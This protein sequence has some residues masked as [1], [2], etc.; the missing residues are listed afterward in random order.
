MGKNYTSTWSANNPFSMPVQKQQWEIENNPNWPGYT[1]SKQQAS[2]TATN[3]VNQQ[4]A[5]TTNQQDAT[6]TSSYAD[7][8]IQGQFADFT[9][10][11]ALEV[12][13]DAN[14]WN[15]L[16][17]E[18][19]KTLV[20]INNPSLYGGFDPEGPRGDNFVNQ[21]TTTNTAT[22]QQAAATNNQQSAPEL[23]FD[24]SNWNPYEQVD[25]FSGDWRSWSQTDR[26]NENVWQQSALDNLMNFAK[27]SGLGEW[28]TSDTSTQRHEIPAAHDWSKWNRQWENEWQHSQIKD[29]QNWAS[30]AY[31]EIEFTPWKDDS[32]LQWRDRSQTD[33]KLQNEWQQG[34]IGNLQQFFGQ[35]NE[36]LNPQVSALQTAAQQAEDQA[37][38]QE[39]TTF[40]DV[41]G[42]EVNTNTDTV[43]D[44][45]ADTTTDTTTDTVAETTVDPVDQ[46]VSTLTGETAQPYDYNQFLQDM[47]TYQAGQPVQ[48]EYIPK[49]SFEDFIGYMRQYSNMGGFG[50]PAQA[51]SYGYGTYAPYSGGV[52]A[53]NPYNNFTNWMNAFKFDDSAPA[54]STNLVNL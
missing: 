20:A 45:V 42:N 53:A 14:R 48:E 5:T 21:Q 26:Y 8:Y 4:T 43:A 39:D 16:P 38:Y 18:D 29:L 51:P 28:V 47:A 35:I 27:S 17:V 25:P 10:D 11:Q 31:P 34:A 3:T 33:T 22:N 12:I 50:G 23:N 36:A 19:R 15:L 32:Y 49:D 9:K 40:T 6:N 7:Q 46:A 30:T 13:G 54:I 41:L 37:Q 44:T 52:Q 1:G 2:Q 24:W